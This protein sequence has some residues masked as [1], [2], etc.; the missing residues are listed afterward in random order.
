MGEVYRARDLKLKREVAIKVLPDDFSRD[1][2]RIPRFQREAEVVASLN[3]PH[4]A[5]IYHIEQAAQSQLLVLEL[6]EGETLADRIVRGPIPVDE[7]L[8]LAMQ[9]A[10]ALEAAHERGIIHRDLKPANIK[11]T[12]ESQVKVLDFGLAKAFQVEASQAHLSNSPTL[13]AAATMQGAI[14]GTAAYMSPE[15]AKGRKVDRRA[16][17]FAFGCVLYEM[18]TG[19]PAFEG[20]DIPEILSRVLQREPDWTLLPANVQPRIRELLR[21]C[22]QKDVRKRRDDAADVRIDLEQALTEP[23]AVQAGSLVRQA[24]HAWIV[25]LAVAVV[26][27]VALGIPAFRHLSERL[28]ALDWSRDG[29]LLLYQQ[30]DP[31]TGWDLWALPMRGDPKPIA[32]ANTP[33]EERSGQFSPDGQWVAYQSNI[34]GL[35]DIYVQPFPGPGGKWKVSTAGGTDPRWRAD[36]QEL[37]FIAP[38][39]KLM[40]VSVRTSSSSFEVGSPTALFQT[41]MVTSNLKHEYAVSRDGRFLVNTVVDDA[42]FPI[43]LLLNWKPPAK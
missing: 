35:F 33:F 1:S 42:T 43:T 12:S 37:F 5:T 26:L 40:A 23:A 34:N 21:L 31:K 8:A 27:I 32:I 22:L 9:I 30:A 28:V 17:I 4:I 14:L 29:R 24:R 16:D 11:I 38:D 15:Q 36:G 39:A 20:E 10:E 25:S 7:A 13:S 6:V 41:R 19:R 2:E 18:L 3:H